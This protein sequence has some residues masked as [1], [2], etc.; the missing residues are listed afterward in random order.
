[1][2]EGSHNLE[3]VKHWRG[4]EGLEKGLERQCFHCH[5]ERVKIG[6]GEEDSRIGVR[7]EY[8]N[9]TIC[10][11]LWPQL[12]PKAVDGHKRE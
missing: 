12:A 10:R 2:D 7:A 1:M 8:V 9:F 4:G 11:T 5:Q 3:A 6:V